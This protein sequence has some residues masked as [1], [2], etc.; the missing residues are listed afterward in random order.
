MGRASNL[1]RDR[2]PRETTTSSLSIHRGSD[3]GSIA[4]EKIAFQPVFREAV[5]RG[6]RL[7]MTGIAGYVEV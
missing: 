3:E 7:D 4:P 6:R 5:S 1:E 2:A